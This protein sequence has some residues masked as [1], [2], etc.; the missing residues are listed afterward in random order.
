MTQAMLVDILS[1][2]FQEEILKKHKFSCMEE[3]ERPDSYSL[4][5]P[6]MSEY[7]HLS[8]IHIYFSMAF[9]DL[10]MIMFVERILNEPQNL[11]ALVL[12]NEPS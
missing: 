1:A 11:F 7:S 5:V 10:S 4:L 6:S 2:I 9:L 8:N 3:A 12:S